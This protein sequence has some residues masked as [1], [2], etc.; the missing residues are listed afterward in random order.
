MKRKQS[1][2]SRS[3]AIAQ[4]RRERVDDEH[5]CKW[6][7]QHS[8]KTKPKSKKKGLPL[9][10]WQKRLRAQKSERRQLAKPLLKGVT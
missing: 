2:R 8:P 1:Q 6:L 9:E 5:A 10:R 7:A 4:T 3:L